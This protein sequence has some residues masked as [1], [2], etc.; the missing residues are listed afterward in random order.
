MT[1]PAEHRSDGD[2]RDGGAVIPR[3]GG[4]VE[5]VREH[6]D[7]ADVRYAATLLSDGAS[8][9]GIASVALVDGAVTLSFATPPPDYLVAFARAFLRSAW[10]SRR[11]DPEPWPA[12]ITRWRA[13]RA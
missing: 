11:E 8:F 1:R 7:D 5:L 2:D 9:D 13:P 3:H 12:R 6:V 4:R 10:L